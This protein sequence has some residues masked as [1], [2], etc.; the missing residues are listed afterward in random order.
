MSERRP[1]ASHV[2][3]P[4]VAFIAVA[5]LF[6]FSDLDRMIAHGWAF[7]AGLHDFPARDS[8]WAKDFVHTGGPRSSYSRRSHSR[9][10]S[11][12]S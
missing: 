5:A 3:W 1:V 9:R 6:A 2:L 8:R 10:C 7:D 4:A 11:S 12:Q